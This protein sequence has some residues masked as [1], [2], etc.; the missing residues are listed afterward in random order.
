MAFYTTECKVLRMSKR[1][2][3]RKPL[4]TYHLGEEVLLHSPETSDL[5]TAHGIVIS[6][7]CVRRRI[8]YVV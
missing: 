3:R 2:S 8:E 7:R 4:I 1:R 6:S 5:V